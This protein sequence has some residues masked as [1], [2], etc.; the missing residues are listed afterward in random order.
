MSNFRRV[1]LQKLKHTKNSPLKICFVLFLLVDAE[2]SEWTAWSAC[3]KPCNNG[4]FMR[5]RF[6]SQALYGG[7]TTCHGESIQ[8]KPCNEQP[9]PGV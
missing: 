7:N 2:W 4:S 5:Q 8:K 1:V 6:C 9:C 3:Q